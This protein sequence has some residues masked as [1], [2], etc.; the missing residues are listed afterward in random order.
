MLKGMAVVAVALSVGLP[1][2]TTST[3]AQARTAA[4][5]EGRDRADGGRSQGDDSH[6]Q[7]RAV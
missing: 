7:R 4:G 6:R 5:A 3:Y 1:A 2:R